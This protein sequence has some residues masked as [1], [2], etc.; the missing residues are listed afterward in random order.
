MILS[1]K[2]SKEPPVMDASFWHRKWEANEIAF[3]GNEVNPLLVDHFDALSLTAGRRVFLPLCGKTRDI[4]WLLLNGYQVAGAE[5]SALAVEQLFAELGVEP[6]ISRVGAL[7][8][9]SAQGIDIF[10]GD[11]F[12]LSATTLGHVDAIYDRAALVAM[13]ADMRIRYTAHLAALTDRAPQLLV[14][15]EYDQSM[16]DGPPFSVSPGDVH[17]HYGDSYD[18]TL[19]LSADVPGGMKGKCPARESVWLLRK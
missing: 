7:D 16:A 9:Y 18:V 12:T 5:L 11:I 15:Y 13:P 14:C 17:R 8:H 1:M 4:H 6:R 2:S 19:L 10:T 3:H